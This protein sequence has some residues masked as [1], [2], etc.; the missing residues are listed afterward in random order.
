MIIV[1]DSLTGLGKKFAEDLGY[2][3][4]SVDAGVSEACLL[5]TRNVGLGKIPETTSRFLDQYKEYVI[6]VVVNG[7]KRYG[8]FYCKAGDRIN[9]LYD[10][11]VIRKI[12][13]SGNQ[14]D[15][16]FVKNS[17][18][19]MESNRKQSNQRKTV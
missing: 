9:K 15:I 7:N 8:P 16:N 5:V 12:S 3:A 6:G 13:G 2:P 11:P 17:L 4:Q 1:Y 19:V 18:S 14:E 10:I